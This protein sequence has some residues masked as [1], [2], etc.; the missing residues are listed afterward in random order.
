MYFISAFFPQDQ[1]LFI[2][3]GLAHL[4]IYLQI[5]TILEPE[6]YGVLE[7]SAFDLWK[8]IMQEH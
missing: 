3:P 2:N 6:I 5:F 1:R 4:F 7:I 8:T